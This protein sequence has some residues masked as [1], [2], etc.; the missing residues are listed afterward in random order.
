MGKR[1][2]CYSLYILSGIAVFQ[3]PSLSLSD[4][5][6]FIVISTIKLTVQLQRDA[7]SRPPAP[8]VVRESLHTPKYSS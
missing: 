1:V 4:L 3:A 5:S 2:Y 8:R 6:H 7:T